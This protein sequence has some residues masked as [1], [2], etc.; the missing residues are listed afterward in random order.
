MYSEA[1]DLIKYKNTI[2]FIY[3][4]IIIIVLFIHKTKITY[5]FFY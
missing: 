4:I 2:Y 1:K 3:N 5:F